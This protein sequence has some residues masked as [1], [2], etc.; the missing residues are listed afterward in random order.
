M[1]RILWKADGQ[2]D[3]LYG[4]FDWGF[5]LTPPPQVTVGQS[6][7]RLP[8]NF[9]YKALSSSYVDYRLVATVKRGTFKPNLM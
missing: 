1:K 8:P 3:K 9:S 6:M 2:L 4:K 7:F 5:T